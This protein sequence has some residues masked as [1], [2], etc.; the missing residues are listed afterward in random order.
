MIE[1]VLG[2][3]KSEGHEL[4]TAP[5]EAGK[6]EEDEEI[7]DVAAMEVTQDGAMKKA[8][9]MPPRGIMRV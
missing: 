8:N 6:D 2:D 7:S 9:K 5:P 4:A 3:L 1:D